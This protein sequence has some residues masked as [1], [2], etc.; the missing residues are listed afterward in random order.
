MTLD[1]SVLESSLRNDLLEN[2]AKNFIFV[3][4]STYSDIRPDSP[5]LE[6]G[7]PS[8]S[9]TY[10]MAIKPGEINIV[11]TKSICY[12]PENID[13]PDGLYSL[14]YSVEPNDRKFVKKNYMRF[15]KAKAKIAELLLTKDLSQ[16]TINKYYKLDIMMQSSEALVNTNK[17]EALDLFNMVQKEIKKLNC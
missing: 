2:P 14:R 13:F 4:D 3:D 17:E 12:S 5:L 6:V 16:E 8:L 1:F 11:N 7:F 15:T 9:K 10:D